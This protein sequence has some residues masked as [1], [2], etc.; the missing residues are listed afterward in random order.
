VSRGRGWPGVELPPLLGELG[1]CLPAAIEHVQL[2]GPLEGVDAAFKGLG[3][4]TG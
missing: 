4:A 3:I 2:A 1:E